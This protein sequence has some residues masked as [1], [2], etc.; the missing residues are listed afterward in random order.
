M[1]QIW[2][3]GRGRKG[4]PGDKRQKEADSLK[5]RKWIVCTRTREP[6]GERAN[7]DRGLIRGEDEIRN[8]SSAN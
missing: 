8:I 5:G 6:F 3:S 2:R 7:S 4:M 1:N